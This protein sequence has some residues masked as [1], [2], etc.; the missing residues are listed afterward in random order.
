VAA[1][2]RE[3]GTSENSFFLN[4][5]ADSFSIF[6]FPTH[7]LFW[8]YMSGNIF[9]AGLFINCIF[10]AFLIERLISF[11]KQQKKSGMPNLVE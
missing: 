1:W 8:R 6:R 4:L 10:Y 7:T 11:I 2:G 5:M 9:I 3:E